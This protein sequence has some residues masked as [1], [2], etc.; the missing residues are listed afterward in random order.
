MISI[1]KKNMDQENNNSLVPTVTS[2]FYN[3]VFLISMTS[4]AEQHL[5]K[6]KKTKSDGVNKLYCAR[7]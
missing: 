1:N 5:I 3:S 4:L 7:G 6:R 2:M